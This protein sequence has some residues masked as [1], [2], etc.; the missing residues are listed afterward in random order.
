MKKEENDEAAAGPLQYKH[1]NTI[2]TYRERLMFICWV[3]SIILHRRH[4]HTCVWAV[5]LFFLF[6]LDVIKRRGTLVVVAA[7]QYSVWLLLLSSS[8]S[9][10]AIRNE[11]RPYTQY[12]YRGVELWLPIISLMNGNCWCS[13]SNKR[14][15]SQSTTVLLSIYIHTHT[16]FYVLHYLF[17]F[18]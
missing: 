16:G 8:S 14:K 5:P 6:F 9:F 7:V 18:V 2:Y 10:G 15:S 13:P 4:N 3:H 1:I 11:R 12:I 17:F